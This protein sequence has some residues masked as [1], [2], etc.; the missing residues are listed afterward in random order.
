MYTV[1]KLPVV[2]TDGQKKKHVTQMN[3]EEV[4]YLSKKV[5]E[6]ADKLND[7]NLHLR[8]RIDVADIELDVFKNIILEG[9]LPNKIIEYNETPNKIFKDEVDYR[10]LIRSTK[11][12]KKLY[13]MGKTKEVFGPCQLCFVVSIK[14]G[15]IITA[16]YNG[17]RDNHASLDSSRYDA[18]LEVIKKEDLVMN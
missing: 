7:D 11:I 10:V 3:A 6:I 5:Y 16:Y 4:I 13:H 8:R 12:E 1:R 9:N 18:N 15:K 2:V 17:V 14:T